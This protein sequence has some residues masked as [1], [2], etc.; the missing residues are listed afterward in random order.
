MH[1]PAPA[2]SLKASLPFG[3]HP[4][5]DGWVHGGATLKLLPVCHSCC[6]SA[7]FKTA[8]SFSSLQHWHASFASVT[9]LMAC[10][11]PAFRLLTAWLWR[12][13][14]RACIS[15][16]TLCQVDSGFIKDEILALASHVIQ[17]AKLQPPGLPAQHPP[18]HSAQV[19]PSCA[20]NTRQFNY[21]FSHP[22]NVH[23]HDL[24]SAS[25]ELCSR[26]LGN[27]FQLQQRC[28]FSFDE[29]LQ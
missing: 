2:A 9:V 21:H 16:S 17:L 11:R 1:W 5:R 14:K 20:A 3:F 10:H 22:Y 28:C 27:T 19:L 24:H 6:T 8:S 29:A 26:S 7:S 25:S 4:G 18:S 23:L 13:A 12:V 15:A